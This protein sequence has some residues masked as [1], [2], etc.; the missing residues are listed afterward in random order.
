[1]TT[2]VTLK[3]FQIGPGEMAHQLKALAAFTEDQGLVP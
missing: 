1:M 3:L 2:S